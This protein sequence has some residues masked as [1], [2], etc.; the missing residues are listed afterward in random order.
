MF[1]A[2][3]I[4]NIL[5]DTFPESTQFMERLY[6]DPTDSEAEKYLQGLINNLGF[7]VAISPFYIAN[8]F[9]AKTLKPALLAT[10]PIDEAA[11][12][13]DDSVSTPSAGAEISIPIGSKPVSTFGKIK[14]KVSE[15][16]TS[17]RGTD[18]TTLGLAIERDNLPGAVLRE[19][20]GLNN[21]L[22]ET[23]EKAYGPNKKPLRKG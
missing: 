3:I 7:G 22:K 20:E 1:G 10:K 11:K 14:N 9:K 16:G 15:Y 17:R 12:L 23:V 21:T 19:V 8:A 4:A 13:L 18:S 6:V 2:I 5:I